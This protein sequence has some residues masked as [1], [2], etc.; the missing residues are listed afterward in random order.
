MALASLVAGFG[1]TLSVAKR[2]D[3]TMFTK[4]LFPKMHQPLPEQSTWSELAPPGEESGGQLAMRALKWGTIYAVSGFSAFSYGVW[5]LVG[6]K[7]VS[8]DL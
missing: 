2:K 6:A 7:D 3:P 4:G 5:K 8:C 1:F